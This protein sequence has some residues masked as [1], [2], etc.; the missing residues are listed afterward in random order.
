MS[1][2]IDR[3]V[4]N[5][6]SSGL[7]VRVL[8][9][10]DFAAPGQWQNTIGFDNM[11]RSVSGES[12]AV[13]VAN[14]RARALELYNDSSQGYQRAISVYQLVDSAGGKVGLSSMAHMLGEKVSP[15]RGAVI[16]RGTAITGVAS[17]ASPRSRR[18]WSRTSSGSRPRY[19]A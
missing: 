18:Q 15:W 3:L 19:R 5:L 17:R 12:D 14:I 16:G 2:S 11:I 4:D 6:P 7:T 9:L 1:K 13:I 10:L 8:G